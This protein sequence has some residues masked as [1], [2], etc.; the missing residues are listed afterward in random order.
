MEIHRGFRSVGQRIEIQVDAKERGFG[1]GFLDKPR[2]LPSPNATLDDMGRLQLLEKTPKREKVRALRAEP[3]AFDWPLVVKPRKLFE[4]LA[5]FASGPNIKNSQ[6][7]FTTGC[8]TQCLA[9]PRK[10]SEFNR[11]TVREN[12]LNTSM[13]VD[14]VCL[15]KR[16]RHQP[17]RAAKALLSCVAPDSAL[18]QVPRAHGSAWVRNNETDTF[19]F[20]SKAIIASKF[21]KVKIRD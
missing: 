19:G 2:R 4:T 3:V 7:V 10:C 11:I 21:P 6:E 9:S 13:A 16:N 1:A 18:V 17:H 15:K 5:H 12:F 14:A 8:N 20:V